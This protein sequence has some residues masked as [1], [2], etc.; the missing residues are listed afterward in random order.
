MPSPSAPRSP[1]LGAVLAL[2]LALAFGAGSAAA[3]PHRAVEPGAYCT[4]PGCAGAER[5]GASRVAGFALAA[6]V[7]VGLGRR[8]QRRNASP[9]ERP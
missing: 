9:E 5:P 4:R 6:L 7:A 3:A 8:A 1:R 2:A